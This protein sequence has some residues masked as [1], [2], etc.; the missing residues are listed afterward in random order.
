MFSALISPCGLRSE[1]AHR[2][3]VPSSSENL[4]FS[5]VDDQQVSSTYPPLVVCAF[6][7]VAVVWLKKFDTLAC[8]GCG[9]LSKCVYCPFGVHVEPVSTWCASRPCRS[10]GRRVGVQSLGVLVAR[11]GRTEPL[12]NLSTFPEVCISESWNPVVFFLRL[13]LMFQSAQQR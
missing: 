4:L 13:F 12:S 3:A 1:R 7:S 10:D 8:D 9:S 2:R 6:S 5:C 11:R